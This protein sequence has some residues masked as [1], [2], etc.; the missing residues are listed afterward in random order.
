MTMPICDTLHQFVQHGSYIKQLCKKITFGS[1]HLKKDQ[2]S[3]ANF[4]APPLLASAPSLRLLWR[5]HLFRGKQNVQRASHPPNPSAC[6][7]NEFDTQHK[8]WKQNEMKHSIAG[9]LHTDKFNQ[10]LKLKFSIFALP[11][12]AD[13]SAPNRNIPVILKI[14]GS[15]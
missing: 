10:N 6:R 4:S 5:R 11:L 1:P 9:E 15:F 13:C 8:N 7:G 12:D 3:Q 2:F 14:R